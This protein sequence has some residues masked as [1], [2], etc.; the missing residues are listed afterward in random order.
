MSDIW[1]LRPSNKDTKNKEG[2][3]NYW[4]KT[5]NEAK[6]PNI[7]IP[8]E[9]KKNIQMLLKHSHNGIHNI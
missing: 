6:M 1:D 2:P 5:T 4:Q 3:H 9:T 7:A 8:S